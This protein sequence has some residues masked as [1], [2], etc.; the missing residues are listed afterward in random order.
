MP[1]GSRVSSEHPSNRQCN[2]E[3]SHEQPERQA[4]PLYAA[5]GSD[6][7]LPAANP[8]R[9]LEGLQCRLSKMIDALA[10]S[11][12]IALDHAIAGRSFRGDAGP[13]VVS[14]EGERIYHLPLQR[15]YD[16]TRIDKGAGERWFCTEEE[17][18]NVGW[19]RVLRQG[20]CGYPQDQE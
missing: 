11:R 14:G 17:A 19:R 10:V 4:P 3:G 7:C 6:C 9:S 2:Q 8:A 15:F 5:V 13:P 1:F 12:D 16:R 18:R 20:R